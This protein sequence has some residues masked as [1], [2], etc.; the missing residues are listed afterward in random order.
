MKLQQNGFLKENLTVIIP[1][2]N[3]LWRIIECL[4]CLNNQTG[5]AGLNVIVMDSSTD[6]TRDLIEYHRDYLKSF[7]NLKI[8]IEPGGL[9]GPA[10]NAGA[11]LT[12]SE[13]VLFL[14]ADVTL[15]D[16]ESLLKTLRALLDKKDHIVSSTIQCK[17]NE[18]VN[19]LFNCFNW[20]LLKSKSFAIG[21]FFACNREKFLSM[22]FNEMLQS[23]ED[24]ELS[25]RWKLIEIV[26]LQVTQ[27]ERRWNKPIWWIKLLMNYLLI[28]CN[29]PLKW[30]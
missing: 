23:A 26:D 24:W 30:W 1:C 29:R 2:K 20:Y 16:S 6:H 8:A 22:K 18:M 12:D 17:E 3:E 14:D 4:T 25:K 19:V 21:A 10:R 27:P 7:N 13:F 9:P 28:K 15:P 11:E 5:V